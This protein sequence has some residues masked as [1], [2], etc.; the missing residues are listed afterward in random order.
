MNSHSDSR[1]MLPSIDVLLKHPDMQPLVTRYGRARS[2]A[3]VREHLAEIR[4]G[5]SS[6]EDPPSPA[7][8][9]QACLARLEQAARASMRRVMNLTG[10]VIHTNLGRSVM[11]LCAIEAV[12]AAM[13][14]PVNLEFDLDQGGRGERD[15]HIETLL[16]RLTGAE[17]ALAVNNNAAAVYLALNTLAHG[18]EVPVSRGELV[19]IGGA[20]R[21][22]DI[23]KRSGVELMEVGTTN[24][25]HLRDYQAAINSQTAALMK[26][27]A[28]NYRIEGFTATVCEAELAQLADEHGLPLL[29]DLGS[30]TLVDL[31]QFGLPYEPTPMEMIKKGVDLVTFSGDKLLG[32]PQ[33]GLVVGKKDLV[34]K[35]RR[36]PM[37]RALRLDKMTIAALEAVLRLYEAPD[38]LCTELPVLRL[39]TRPAAEIQEAALRLLPAVRYTLKPDYEAE[40]AEVKS[41]FG[42]GSFP[43]ELLQS[44]AIR[45]CKPGK[46]ESAAAAKLAEAFR[47]LPIPVVGRVHD[48][49][50][51]LDLR[52]LEDQNDF[53]AQLHHLDVGDWP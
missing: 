9:V 30:G 47:A 17:A 19:E 27:H 8:V 41:Q 5:W 23:M 13:M 29:S 46:Q 37:K 22:P 12:A 49:A 28:S 26:V 25:T 4:L 53:V 11:P 50:L 38:Q 43:V 31:R 24:R 42:S 16:T 48:G 40:V 20:F 10:T 1:R 7:S 51:F 52:C 32:G 18:R 2:L 39:L 15:D 44:Y 3:V 45:I 14:N 21:V 34:D 33:A 35:L 36:N 6:F